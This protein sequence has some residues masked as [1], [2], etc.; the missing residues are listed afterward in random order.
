MVL[1]V[2]FKD[3]REDYISVWSEEE[4]QAVLNDPQYERVEIYECYGCL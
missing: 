4:Y 1:W 3:G 2:K